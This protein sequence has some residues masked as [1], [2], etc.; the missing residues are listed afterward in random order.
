M[1]SVN[2]QWILNRRPVGDIEADDLKFVESPVPEPGAGEILIRNIYL[3]LDPTNRIWMSDREQYMPP[4]EIGE[5]MRGGTLGVV[6]KS[7]HE[8]FQEGDIALPGLGNWQD[9]VVVPGDMANK[10]PAGLGIPLDAWMSVLG[11]TGATAYFGLLD[12]GQPKPGETVVVS[13]AGGAVGSIVGQIA[14]IKGC[15]VVGIAGSDD[16]CR[17]VV[18]ELG[19]DACIN[20]KTESVEDRLDELCPNGIDVN[21]ENVGGPIMDAILARINNNARIAL[22]GL[23]SSYNAVDPVPGPYNFSMLL[24]RRARCEGFIILDYLPRIPEFIAEAGPW[25]AEGK[26]KYKTDIVDGLENAP[27]TVKRLFEGQNTG[28][29]LIRLAPEPQA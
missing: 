27:A 8:G 16:K 18:D 7:N 21:F 11:M 19:F 4:V 6:V 29:L 25:L 14:K 15:R 28:K 5:V 2:R 24:M 9:Y 12:V 22:C 23:I 13:A 17:W 20:Y 1:S 26:L 10:V 3:S